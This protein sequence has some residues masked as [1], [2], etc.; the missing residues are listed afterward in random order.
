MHV[1]DGIKFTDGTPLDVS[2][3]LQNLAGGTVT[4]YWKGTYSTSA[5][6]RRFSYGP[7]Y[8]QVQVIPVSQGT[9]LGQAAGV[10]TS[11]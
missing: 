1:R 5:R 6:G 8:P 4:L 11:R 2:C 10:G 9:D 3:P 7:P